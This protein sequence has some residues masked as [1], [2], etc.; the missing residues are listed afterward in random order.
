[1]LIAFQDLLPESVWNANIVK[2]I[3]LR[4]TLKCVHVKKLEKLEEIIGVII[5][6]LEKIFPL[7][8]F[9]ANYSLSIYNDIFLG[10]TECLSRAR[11]L[12]SFLIGIIYYN[13]HALVII[14][15]SEVFH[16]YA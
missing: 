1:M 7:R 15:M 3:S 10:Y 8:I 11:R 4:F 12:I 5:C 6:K 16:G 13:E 14:V 9:W 2:S